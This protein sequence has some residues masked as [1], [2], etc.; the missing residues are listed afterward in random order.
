MKK[1]WDVREGARGRKEYLEYVLELYS[2]R[3]NEI[4]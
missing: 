3:M 4:G 2:L 1:S